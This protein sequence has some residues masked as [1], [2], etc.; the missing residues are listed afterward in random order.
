MI[1]RIKNPWMNTFLINA[2]VLTVGVM[3]LL[4]CII[5]DPP[6]LIGIRTHFKGSDLESLT[7]VFV[8]TQ[9]IQSSSVYRI[10]IYSDLWCGV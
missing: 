3:I 1:V 10:L 2:M 6:I 8:L 7:A 5:I 9:D 4:K